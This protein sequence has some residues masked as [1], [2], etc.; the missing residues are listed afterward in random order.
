MTSGIQTYLALL[1]AGLCLF[2]F[3]IFIPGGILGLIGAILLVGAV[4]AGFF[5]FDPPWNYVS[6]VAISLL[7]GINI[8]AWI[9]IL[10][11]TRVGKS[12][13]LSTDG[14]SFK[15][16]EERPDWVGKEGIAKTDLRPS[17]LAVIDGKTLDVITDAVWVSR[18]ASIRVEKA[19]GARI[20]VREIQKSA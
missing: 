18:G 3:E 11:K 6:L 17:G 20:L 4:I 15:S 5:A 19:E 1:V 8:W 7:A 12:M 16:A 14:S 9:F 10:P 2:G 13:T